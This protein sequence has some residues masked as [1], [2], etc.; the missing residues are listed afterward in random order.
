MYISWKDC[1][2]L[3][4]PTLVVKLRVE[5]VFW[6]IHTRFGS[7]IA[8]ISKYHLIQITHYDVGYNHN[9]NMWQRVLTIVCTHVVTLFALKCSV[10]IRKNYTR[11]Y[12]KRT[13]FLIKHCH[14]IYPLFFFVFTLKWMIV[15]PSKRNGLLS[16]R[17]L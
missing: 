4:E 3:N 9:I 6:M 15:S 10:I 7:L 11:P 17:Y 14:F 8:I 1:R 16:M 13:V 5:H 12:I 2:R